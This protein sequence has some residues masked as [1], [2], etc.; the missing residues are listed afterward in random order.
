MY[1]QLQVITKSLKETH[2][3]NKNNM[4]LLEVVENHIISEIEKLQEELAKVRQMKDEQTSRDE[5]YK[6]IINNK[7][8]NVIIMGGNVTINQPMKSDSI[9][10][11]IT[12]NTIENLNFGGK[13]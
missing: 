3:Q 13:K 11:P 12:A 10:Q 7:D 1:K 9:E 2:E 8:V 6:G 5:K 4:K